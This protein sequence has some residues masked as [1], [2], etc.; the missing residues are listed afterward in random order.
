MSETWKWAPVK[1]VKEAAEELKAIVR[2]KYPEAE[3]SLSRA[4]DDQHIWLLWTLVDVDDPDEIRALTKER[5]VDLLVE[6]HVAVYVS[7]TRRREMIDGYG[8]AMARKTG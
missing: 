1:R 4:P 6:D 8:S 2:E 5:E 3:F 7:P